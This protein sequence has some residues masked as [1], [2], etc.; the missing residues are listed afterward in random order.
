MSTSLTLVG[1]PFSTFTRTVRMAL[2]HLDVPYTLERTLPHTELAYKYN[3]FGRIPSLLHG[4]K[5]IFESSAIRDYI[6]A[7]FDARLTPTD[8]E[9]RLKVQQMISVLS[10][11]VFHH[12]V[13]G[14]AKPREKYESENKPENEIVALLE[15]PLK[16]AGKIIGAVDDMVS[17][18]GPFL[19]GSQLTWA[20]Y[21]VY[22]A[23]ADLY[24]LPEGAYFQEKGP[25]LYQWFTLFKYRPEVLETFPDTVADM[26]SKKSSL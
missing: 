17:T 12:V 13:F 2:R 22:P 24:S 21:F 16:K 23:M 14:V 19:C 26:R 6:D 7:V 4:D 10:D 25:R 18:Q 15:K 8:L 9:T 20:D 3:P 5:V 1:A 11:Y